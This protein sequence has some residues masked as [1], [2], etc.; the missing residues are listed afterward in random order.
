MLSY[1]QA[2][3]LVLEN[4]HTIGSEWVDISDARGGYLFNDIYAPFDMPRFDNS[5]MDGF[6]IRSQDTIGATTGNPVALSLAGEVKTGVRFVLDLKDGK[7]FEIST[8]SKIP[9]GADAVVMKEEVEVRD[10]KVFISRVINKGEN[11][12]FKGEDFKQGFKILTKGVSITPQVIALFAAMGIKT[13]QIFKRPQIS[14]ISSG[15]ELVE[16]GEKLNEYQI[17]NSNYYSISAVLSKIGLCIKRH[18]TVRDDIESIL[19]AL[20]E[21]LNDSDVILISG[22]V[23]VGSVDYVREALKKLNVEDI[24]WKVGIKPGKPTFFGRSQDFLVFGLPGNP[25]SSFVSTFLFVLPALKKIMGS[26]DYMNVEIEATLENNFIKKGNRKAFNRGK[27]IIRD[28]HYYVKVLPK[29][30]SH[31][32]SSF[33]ES[34]CLIVFDYEER[35]YTKGDKVRIYVT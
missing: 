12:R 5:A 23:S 31:I 3:K 29:Q 28:G 4:S 10:D 7:A 14:F 2:L 34:N 22:G 16:P 6:A 9:R 13:V 20:T 8:G 19:N 32:F 17:Y 35:L 11:I 30:G 21:C 1:D 27:Y 15:T 33:A 25:V 24:L 18:L 26:T